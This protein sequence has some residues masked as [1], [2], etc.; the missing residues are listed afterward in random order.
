[1]SAT[2]QAFVSLPFQNEVGQPCAIFKL[3]TLCRLKSLKYRIDNTAKCG[4]VFIPYEFT[5]CMHDNRWNLEDGKDFIIK[6]L[7]ALAADEKKNHNNYVFKDKFWFSCLW[8]PKQRCPMHQ[9]GKEIDKYFLHNTCTRCCAYFPFNTQENLIFRIQEGMVYFENLVI[10]GRLFELRA[11]V[12]QDMRQQHEFYAC[13][14]L[15]GVWTCYRHSSANTVTIANILGNPKVCV[16]MYSLKS[17]AGTNVTASE[18]FYKYEDIIKNCAEPL[19][20]AVA[21]KAIVLKREHEPV[22]NES[23]PAGDIK[24]VPENKIAL[25]REHELVT[26]ES[27]PAEDIATH[28]PEPLVEAVAE[29][30]I[31]LKREYGPVTNESKPAEGKFEILRRFTNRCFTNIDHC[32]SCI[33]AVLQSLI[34]TQ[35][36]NVE[37]KLCNG[38]T[39]CYYC[40]MVSLVRR[41]MAN[42]HAV[43]AY[44]FT[45]SRSVFDMS[46]HKE[47][48]PA[49]YISDLLNEIISSER[50]N[51]TSS[52]AKRKFMVRFQKKS[53]A[54]GSN[55]KVYHWPVCPEKRNVSLDDLMAK[56]ETLCTKCNKMTDLEPV[57]MPENLVI[58]ISNDKSNA[59]A[60]VHYPVEWTFQG[61]RYF[62][63]SVIVSDEKSRHYFTCCKIFDKWKCYDDTKVTEGSVF[64]IQGKVRVLVY[65]TREL[66]ADFLK[67]SWD[68][69]K[70]FY[71]LTDG[72]CL[73]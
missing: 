5:K 61:V 70:R 41:F 68:T 17:E 72:D 19:V 57:Y 9:I 32:N 65:V 48:D 1:M 59:D 18:H 8:M 50:V 12:A 45:L 30:K 43:T 2:L 49:V 27:K 29:N 58:T 14:K 6:L 42:D 13:C 37:G 60:S 7:D 52:I 25:K 34:Q 63:S 54:C 16:L 11:V 73:L 35:L 40:R 26:N 56:L 33:N 15:K 38:A 67:Y 69:P 62:L 21:E 3:C 4:E 39:N 36:C 51:H 47:G 20:E 53:C 71:R 24:V 10:Q 66:T 23:K 22:T 55:F 31:V 46:E 44:D 28:C 64:D